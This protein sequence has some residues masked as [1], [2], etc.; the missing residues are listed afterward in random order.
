MSGD[1][2]RSQHPTGD[3]SSVGTVADAEHLSA[4]GRRRARI[5][6][7]RS[8]DLT[9]RITVGVIGTVVLVVAVLLVASGA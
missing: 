7:R 3:N 1:T 2:L 6:E 5:A 8:L 4:W 9:Y